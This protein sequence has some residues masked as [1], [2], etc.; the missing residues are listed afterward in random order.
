MVNK[1]PLNPL[2]TTGLLTPVLIG[3]YHEMFTC[4]ANYDKAFKMLHAQTCIYETI[5]LTPLL[6][7][8]KYDTLFLLT[9]RQVV[10]MGL[11]TDEK[12]Y[13]TG[14]VLPIIQNIVRL[15]EKATQPDINIIT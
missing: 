1:S 12:G 14:D 7:S 9:N 3:S 13:V 11:I 2:S 5:F 8:S 6:I 4:V 15:T 10:L